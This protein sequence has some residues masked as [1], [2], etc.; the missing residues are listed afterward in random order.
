M[1]KNMIPALACIL[2]LLAP[3]A[4]ADNLGFDGKIVEPNCIAMASWFSC[5]KI[6]TAPAGIRRG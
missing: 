5:R 3:L 6:D 4:E 1:Q 2:T